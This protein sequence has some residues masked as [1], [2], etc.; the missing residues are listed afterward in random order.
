MFWAFGGGS[1][2]CCRRLCCWAGCSGGVAGCCAHCCLLTPGLLAAQPG[3]SDSRPAQLNRC[4][5]ITVDSA[6]IALK[7]GAYTYQRISK[8]MHYKTPFSHN[9]YMKSLEVYENYITLIDNIIV[10]QN[11]AWHITQS[12]WNNYLIY[13]TINEQHHAVTW[14]V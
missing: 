12:G 1:R 14:S 10:T 3:A 7:N 11:H 2:C 4:C 8:Q 13:A 9:S 6:T 5:Y